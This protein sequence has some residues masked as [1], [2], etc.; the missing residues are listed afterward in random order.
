MSDESSE[1]IVTVS[2][3]VD[4][5]N[6][7]DSLVDFLSF[8]GLLAAHSDDFIHFQLRGFLL[9]SALRERYESYEGHRTFENEAAWIW[10][11]DTGDLPFVKW[12]H[13][14]TFT[15]C[16]TL[17]MDRAADAGHLEFIRWLHENRTEGCTVQ[18][19]DLAAG[20][21]H[22]NVVRFLHEHRSEGCTFRAMD[23]A[24]NNGHLDV[25]RFL[26]ECRDE[27]CTF[28]AMDFAAAAVL[29]VQDPEASLDWLVRDL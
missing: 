13:I 29:V 3:V 18:A 15:G 8:R 20:N 10:V 26:H 28:R 4:S 11:A 14:H 2:P 16:T 5:P 1:M 24:A 25:V 23:L 6:P 19:M 9:L 7:L 27:G 17:V 12:L 22:L 21:G